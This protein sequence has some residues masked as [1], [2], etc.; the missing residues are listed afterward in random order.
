LELGLNGKLWGRVEA[1]ASTA[2]QDASGNQ[3]MQ[4]LANSPRH[5]PK[6]RL[7]T[8]FLRDRLFLSG[9]LQYISS[10]ITGSGNRL[11]GALVADFTATARV[12][13]RFDLQCGLR[14]ALD[15]RYED[16]VY[17]TVDRLRGDGRS[18]FVKL[19]WRVWE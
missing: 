1:S 18:V 2:F 11:G 10:R 9:A 17:L 13:P 4:R 5:L 12:H 15:R 6:L 16:P 19:V 3:A 8:P 14:N 7:G